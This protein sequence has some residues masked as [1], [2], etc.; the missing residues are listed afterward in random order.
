MRIA[1]PEIITPPAPYGGTL[2]VDDR[3]L[4]V[5]LSRAWP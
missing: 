5:R 1:T 3:R 2:S 4:S